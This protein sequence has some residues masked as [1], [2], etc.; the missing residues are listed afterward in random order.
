MTALFLQ[1]NS[2]D[3]LKN[4]PADY[5]HCVMT[6]PPY[7]GLRSYRDGIEDWGDWVGQLGGEP[8]PEL[9]IQHLIQIMQEVR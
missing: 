2:R 4:F 5:F 9:Y 8:T 3:V 7:F 1:G 6:S